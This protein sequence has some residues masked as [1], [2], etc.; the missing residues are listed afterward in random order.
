M[1]TLPLSVKLWIAAEPVDMRR[2]HDGLA[3]IVRNDWKRELFAGHLFIFVGKR[4]D[5]CKILFWDRGGFV[6]Y[7]K[8]LER[9]CFRL[10]KVKSASTHTEL[11]ST[12][13]AMLLDGIDVNMVRRARHWQTS[14]EER[15]KKGST[16]QPNFDQT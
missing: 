13:L 8:R 9:G 1:L 6:L 15:E 11:D 10:P 12:E 5:R 7:Y 3:A 16:D 14:S 4:R 2:G